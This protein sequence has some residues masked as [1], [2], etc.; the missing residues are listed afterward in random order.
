MS[1]FNGS[2][3]LL[4]NYFRDKACS[5]NA[6]KA[7]SRYGTFFAL[8]VLAFVLPAHSISQGVIE[9]KTLDYGKMTNG[10]AGTDYWMLSQSTLNSEESC[11]STNGDVYLLFEFWRLGSNFSVAS[12]SSVPV[13]FLVARGT[14]PTPGQNG[15]WRDAVGAAIGR[16]YQRILV[17]IN[18]S[19]NNS[20]DWYVTVANL[21]LP[22]ISYTFW[23][24]CVSSSQPAPCP[25][26][27]FDQTP[28][29]G[30]GTCRNTQSVLHPE[31][32]QVCDCKRGWGD[33]DCQTP[34]PLLSNG[35]VV[36]AIVEPGQWAYWQ[37][38]VTMPSNSAKKASIS[39]PVVLVEMSRGGN[40]ID[41]DGTM[42]TG[43][44]GPLFGGD[45]IL[46]VMP[47][48]P[49]DFNRVPYINDSLSNGDLTSARLQ[50][51]FHFKM[52]NDLQHYP[53]TDDNGRRII[54]F[55]VAVYNYRDSSRL[56]V[57]QSRQRANVTLRVRWRSI[58][59]PSAPPLCPNNCYGRG[60]CSEP[61]ADSMESMLMLPGGGIPRTTNFTC[62]CQQGYG[63][64]MC[65][66]T[67]NE[68]NVTTSGHTASGVLKPGQWAFS[69]V[70]IDPRS[71][72]VESD[73]MRLEWIVQ[74]GSNDY[75]WKYYNALLTAN[76]EA[77]PRVS[78]LMAS[79]GSDEF[80]T[81]GLVRS[82]NKMY[83]MD[84]LKWHPIQF[85]DLTPGASYV[86]GLYNSDYVRE[87]SYNYTLKVI[88][89]TLSHT[90]LRPYMSVVIGVSASLLLC[91]FVTLCRRILQRYGWGPFRQRAADG[92][93]P[94]DADGNVFAQVAQ[95]QTRQGGVP[96][97]VI[98]TFHSYEYRA[99]RAEKEQL[100]KSRPVAQQPAA[101]V[102][103]AARGRSIVELSQ[104][105]AIGKPEATA[106]EA[107]AEAPSQSSGPD[108]GD[109]GTC[110]G[111]SASG[112]S[113][114]SAASDRDEEPQCAVCL[115]EY[116]E[117]EVITQLPCKHEFHGTCIRK[118]LR[119]HYTC[120]ICRVLLIPDRHE[121]TEPGNEDDGSARLHIP[122]PQSQ[123]PQQQEQQHPL[124]RALP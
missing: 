21:S 12:R 65:E 4:G 79:V 56:P 96:A 31:I 109:S 105:G 49:D 43:A 20:N 113:G 55:Y 89:P 80:T 15:I 27:P 112:G 28:C 83:T 62:V 71:F 57:R 98:D 74:D 81:R 87:G 91:L 23:V 116:E 51:N 54:S 69:V 92:G 119:T 61:Q 64:P 100:T 90:W 107:A 48:D 88:I 97:N 123:Q 66:G 86:L 7:Q 47:K 33:I 46:L 111:G 73:I 35:D 76:Y 101:T 52:L 77:F 75:P 40:G 60:N 103:A 72:D 78:T 94:N 44:A 45:P 85:I 1:H 22:S 82:Y 115:C 95:T 9:T 2:I 41:A 99:T 106:A 122:P 25:H 3:S 68:F 114:N 118:W 67:I 84:D 53:A 6:L 29:G 37:F 121:P 17:P 117:G 34:A 93:A 102:A 32:S 26:L 14:Q 63:G 5:R 110:A 108:G 36:S 104:R 13:N 30:K 8:L 18:A 16:P 124:A 11:V 24:K 120:P 38:N 70:T 39:D 50:Q 58:D 59:T 42:G 19:T 10:S